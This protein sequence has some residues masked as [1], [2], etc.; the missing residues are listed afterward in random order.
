VRTFLRASKDGHTHCTEQHPSRRGE[1]AAPQDDGTVVEIAFMPGMTV[2]LLKS[3]SSRPGSEISANIVRQYENTLSFLRRSI[4]QLMSGA[5]HR[6]PL[7]SAI[8]HLPENALR[9]LEY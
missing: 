6:L 7:I 4:A 5:D 9:T 2:P 3:R 1:G 8:L